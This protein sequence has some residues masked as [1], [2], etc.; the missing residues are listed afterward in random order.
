MP[1][2]PTRYTLADEHDRLLLQVAARAEL[3]LTALEKPG[4][5]DAEMNALLDYLRAE[6]LRQ[7]CDE[8]ALLI[9]GMLN[10]PPAAALIEDHV[11]LRIA[12]ELLTEAADERHRR[13]ASEISD[14]VTDLFTQLERHCIAEESL[15]SSN[16]HAT[17][18]TTSVNRRRPHEWYPLTEGQV[19]DVDVLPSDRM[20]DALVDRLLRM[21]R[22]EKVELRSARD[23]RPLWR[24]LSWYDP[25][26]YNLVHLLEGPPRWHVVC[27]RR[28][29]T[30]AEQ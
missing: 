25:G 11:R 9:A 21:R 4:W 27:T 30:L 20:V 15:L 2:E 17:F 8:E 28:P 26:G 7:V 10:E 23:L 1:S 24:R 14:I 19:I 18:P 12:V 16:G 22:G 3:L 13:S 6:V 29:R 5:P